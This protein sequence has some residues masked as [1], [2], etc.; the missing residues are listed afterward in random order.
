MTT[1]E[2]AQSV[3]DLTTADQVTV[4]RRVLEELL[5]IPDVRPLGTSAESVDRMLTATEAATLTGT[6]TR[7]LYKHRD[8]IPGTKRYGRAIRFSEA[9]LQRWMRR[10]A[11]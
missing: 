10:H 9:G 1:R 4:P 3:L 5:A 11:A 7:Y 2:L 8:E 6:S